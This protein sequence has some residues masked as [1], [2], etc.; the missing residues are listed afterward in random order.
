[1]KRTNQNQGFTIVEMLTVMGI[2]AVLIGLLIPALNQ[3]KDF[4]RQIQQK[5]QFHGIEV[6]L[7]MF[8]N[9]SAFGTYPESNDNIDSYD[10]TKS[11]AASACGSG[12]LAAATAYCGANK[13]AEALI[14]L[15]YLGVHPNTALRAD[16]G[17][18]VVD[19]T[20]T[21]LVYPVY[22]LST[23]Y[24]PAWETIDENLK[25]RKGPFIDL[26]NA[27]AF[28]MDEVY[29]TGAGKLGLFATSTYTEPTEGVA[30]YPLVL[31]DIFSKK[32][33]GTGNKKTGM[34]V[35]YYRARTAYTQQNFNNAN[36][37]RDDIYYYP[38]NLNLLALGTPEDAIVHPLYANGGAAADLQ[39]FESIILNKQVTTIKRPYRAGTYILMSAGKD[40]LYGTG[41]DILNFDK[42]SER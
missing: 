1:M 32:R 17:N 34:P 14:G 29:G 22:H 18:C 10:G 35:L 39:S 13:M 37:I 19:K 42:G 25:A 3:V 30:Y 16:G 38:D 4:S 26:E 2:I 15:D 20:N 24:S 27:N 21:Q 28:R 11:V 5:A 33:S 6:A 7:E 8:K 12:A 36:A 40:G 31:C 23:N 41:D 9:D